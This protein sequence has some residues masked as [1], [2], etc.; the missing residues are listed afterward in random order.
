MWDIPDSID[1]SVFCLSQL[2]HIFWWSFLF[3][4]LE[5]AEPAVKADRSQRKG[6]GEGC[7]AVPHHIRS[8]NPSFLRGQTGTHHHLQHWGLHQSHH[9][10]FR[11]WVLLEKKGRLFSSKVIFHFHTL[12]DLNVNQYYFS[13]SLHLPK[14]FRWDLPPLPFSA[15]PHFS[16]QLVVPVVA[17]CWQRGKS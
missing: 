3:T 9:S 14:T 16:V 5:Q 8:E 10:V 17:D 7:A 15:P 2:C 6:A 13:Y 1:T 4:N 12:T 11:T